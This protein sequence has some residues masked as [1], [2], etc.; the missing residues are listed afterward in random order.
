MTT[1]VDSKAN[2]NLDAVFFVPSLEGGI[3]RVVAL[4]AIGLKEHGYKIEVWSASPNLG[5]ASYI[6]EKLNVRYLGRGSLKS[7]LKN[8]VGALRSAR[9]NSLIS[10]SFHANCL[11]LIAARLANASTQVI[12]SDH[13]SIDSALQ[14]LPFFQ[15]SAWRLLI[16]FLYRQADSHI[17]VSQGVAAAMARFSGIP[18]SEI[19][20]IPNPVISDEIFVQSKEDL[21]HPFFQAGEPLILFVGRLSKE[22][23]VLTLLSAFSQ[24]QVN[25]KSKL[26]LVGDGPEKQSLIKLSEAYGIDDRVS[27]VGHRNNPYPYFLRADLV[28]LS[29]TREG[30]PTVLI[31]ALAFGKRVVSTDCPSGPREILCNGLFGELVEMKN[32]EAFA[33]A[34]NRALNNKQL[35][36]PRSYLAKYSVQ[37]AVSEYAKILGPTYVC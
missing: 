32:A 25:I 15:R 28:A 22:K 3:G 11:A 16:K 36:V 37:S 10:A 8:L 26:I 31:E 18:L 7:A 23:N 30:L 14:E 9:P 12:I 27:F 17:G 5:Y 33:E 2:Q 20:V 29:S 19:S 21:A 13:P 1:I 4:L 24:L 34:L 6:E 35:N